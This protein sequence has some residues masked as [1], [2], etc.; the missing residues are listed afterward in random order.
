MGRVCSNTR[1]CDGEETDSPREGVGLDDWSTQDERIA[2]Q[3]RLGDGGEALLLLG[4]RGGHRVDFFGAW[5]DC[6]GATGCERAA[7]T[8]LELSWIHGVYTRVHTRVGCAR[9]G[10]GDQLSA[11]DC[12]LLF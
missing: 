11:A 10:M 2:A 3:D 9:A 6:D 4:R 12:K 1:R 5:P 8:C 7:A